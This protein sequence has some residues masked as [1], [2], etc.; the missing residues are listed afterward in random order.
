[1]ANTYEINLINNYNGIEYF[2]NIDLSHFDQTFG[3][4][5]GVCTVCSALCFGID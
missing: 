2:Q 3:L 4:A 1:M 5:K